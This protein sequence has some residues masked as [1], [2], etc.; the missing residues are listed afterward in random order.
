MDAILLNKLVFYGNL[1]ITE[2]ERS[3]RQRIKVSVRI[4]LD[5]AQAAAADRIEQA[6]NYT[7]ARKEIQFLI[8]TQEFHLIEALANAV[9]MR[10]LG[11]FSGAL[12][13]TTILTKLD[14]R[15][16][17]TVIMSKH[18]KAA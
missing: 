15:G 8:E 11:I 3:K 7:L 14:I 18:K 17:P 16:T 6:L 2:G 12:R 9:N 13:V 10:L 1:G 4:D 5:L